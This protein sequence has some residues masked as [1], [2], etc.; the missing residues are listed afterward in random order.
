MSMKIAFVVLMI[1]ALAL[2]GLGVFGITDYL[3]SMPGWKAAKKSAPPA[4]SPSAPLGRA[5]KDYVDSL[6]RSRNIG[7]IFSLLFLVGG[8]GLAFWVCRVNLRHRSA[9]GARS[10]LNGG[11]VADA[12]C[13]ICG[14]KLSSRA[15]AGGVCDFCRKRAE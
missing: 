14:A 2:T 5:Y 3:I 1:V 6:E 10:D 7:F 15:R 12:V 9:M 13:T 8:M 11:K 4:V